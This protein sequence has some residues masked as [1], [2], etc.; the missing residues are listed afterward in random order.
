MLL[1]TCEHKFVKLLYLVTPS[2]KNI[3]FKLYKQTP[4]AYLLYNTYINYI[5]FCRVTKSTGNKSSIS[6]IVM[7][8]PI[9]KCQFKS[10]GNPLTSLTDNIPLR[11][12]F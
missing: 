1:C 5:I 11:L 9:E 12:D 3:R 4:K 10:T 2:I 6:F 7:P 8:S